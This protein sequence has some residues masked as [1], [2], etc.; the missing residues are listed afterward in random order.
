[1]HEHEFVSFWDLWTA[2]KASSRRLTQPWAEPSESVNKKLRVISIPLNKSSTFSNCL[3]LSIEV[4]ESQ[5]STKM[6][7]VPHTGYSLST[8]INLCLTT[9]KGCAWNN[10][11]RKQNLI[12]V[13]ESIS[14][15]THFKITKSKNPEAFKEMLATAAERLALQHLSFHKGKK[16]PKLHKASFLCKCFA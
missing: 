15:T 11:K 3:P 12:L 7:Y 4:H 2:L 14:R 1:M 9:V 10:P 16:T 8:N 5:Q 6:P 13:L